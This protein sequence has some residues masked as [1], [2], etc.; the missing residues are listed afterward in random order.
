MKKFII[1]TTI[2]V[3]IAFVAYAFTTHENNS[4]TNVKQV[5]DKAIEA[6]S[7][8]P[9]EAVLVKKGELQTSAK[10]KLL[11][12]LAGDYYMGNE[13]A[14]VLMIEYASLSCPHCAHFHQ[15]VLD[16]LI[17]S[18]INTD[19]VRYIYRDFPL[20]APALDATKLSMCADKDKY[21]NFL[22]VLFKSQENWMM[23]D[24]YKAVLKSIGK[25]G[26]VSEDE[27]DK[28]LADKEVESRILSVKKDAID[29]LG[30]DSTPTIFING[31]E[32]EGEHTHEAV[33]KYIDSLLTA[34]AQ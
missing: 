26:G 27:F 16:D 4:N 25:L 21:F 19:K 32:Y 12:N 30:V 17:V 7:G 34:P 28:C 18:H 3:L 29:V 31:I 22:K 20:N 11:Q 9:Q 1:P 33:A 14:P 15:A 13:Y 8:Q 5:D 24:D 6:A 10:A 23:A 2:F